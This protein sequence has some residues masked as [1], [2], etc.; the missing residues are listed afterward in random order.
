MDDITVMV[1][2]VEAV[3]LDTPKVEAVPA[4]ANEATLSPP[5]GAPGDGP[6]EN[7]P[8]EAPVKA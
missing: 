5:S 7:T 4:A 3:K 1:S 2:M 6:E 8:A